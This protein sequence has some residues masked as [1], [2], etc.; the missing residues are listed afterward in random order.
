MKLP[1]ID[2]SKGDC[3]KPETSSWLSVREE[4]C[5]ALESLGGFMAIM[6]DKISSEL[7]DTIFGTLKDLFDSSTELK[8]KNRYEE[9]PFVGHF[10]YNPV[11]EDLGIHNPNNPEE[12]EKFTHLFWPN[13]NNKFRY[14][15]M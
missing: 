13:G 11:H 7:H 5:E 4:V 8:A 9:N 1:V 6:P 14:V 10:I 3:M 15:S 2:F 12:T